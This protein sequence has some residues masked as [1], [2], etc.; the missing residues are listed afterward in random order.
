M[1]FPYS[2]PQALILNGQS[3]SGLIQIG[4]GDLV[5]VEMPAVWTAAAITFQTSSDGVT[6]QNLFDDA[7]VEIKLVVA[8]SQNIAIGEGANAKAEHFR[9]AAYIKIRSGTSAVPVAQAQNSTV[10]LVV[11]KMVPSTPR[12]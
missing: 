6:F 4:A 1:P 9:G 11:R 10:T 12:I 3:L 5:A 7:G 8:A 2:R